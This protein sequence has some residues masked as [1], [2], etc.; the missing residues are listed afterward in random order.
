MSQEYRGP[1]ASMPRAQRIRVGGIAV[2]AFLLVAL[3][4][5]T[6]YT[7]EPEE[8]A[9]V[10]RFGAYV[11]TEEPGLHFKWPFG[12]EKAVR[13]KKDRNQ[14]EEFGFRTV[15][16]DVR[17]QYSQQDYS[18]ESIMLTG[19]L[20]QADVEWTVQYNIKA[21]QAYLFRV[22]APER[23]LRAIAESAM[24]AVIGDR[25]V[26][27]VLTVG[28]TEIEEE[29][30]TTLQ[31]IL[32]QYESGIHIVFVKLQDVFPPE[33]VKPSFTDVEAAKQ[34]KEEMILQ[35]QKS[36]NEAIPAA[37]GVAKQ[38][39]S[40]AEGYAIDRVNRAKGEAERFSKILA[41]YEK[42]PE[43]TRKRIYLETMREVLPRLRS[44]VILDGEAGGVLPLLDLNALKGGE[45]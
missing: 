9:V 31:S 40:E 39:I 17:T 37:E 25:S 26:T 22:R 18:N 34:E 19:D 3:A 41:E 13:V 2:A 12:L 27:E 44:K 24:R 20:N 29:C 1:G 16:A 5:T 36:Y 35:A 4:T 32:N 6:W 42:A 43:V 8:V 7:V 15:R 33:A 21:P 28:K 14:K 23:T 45:R 38:L 10:T 11:R 30:R